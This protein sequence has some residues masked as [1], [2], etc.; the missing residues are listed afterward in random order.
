MCHKNTSPVYRDYKSGKVDVKEFRVA[1]FNVR[2]L[3]DENKRNSLRKDI[4]RYGVDVCCLQETKLKAGIEESIDGVELCS[5]PTTQE[6][7][8][9]GFI[10]SK[11]WSSR[12]YK[13]WKISDRIA[14]IQLNP[15][16]KDEKRMNRP[17]YT[18]RKMCIGI[19]L[20]V[21]IKNNRKL[22][23]IINCYA[24]HS[25]LTK[26]N[27]KATE[28][29]YNKLEQVIKKYKNK[30]SLTIIAGDMNAT[31]GKQGE[32]TCIGK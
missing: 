11:K 31:V 25:G 23:T 8:G 4:D 27:P 3:N 30:S 16:I 28:K 18:S 1:T 22:I 13:K 26:E 24:P 12:I 2:G 29:C 21:K 6:A 15:I 32:R 14:V 20:K 10:V 17:I 19:R 9:L 7:Y 5:F